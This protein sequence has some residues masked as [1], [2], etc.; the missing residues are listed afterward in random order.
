MS[1]DP[2]DTAEARIRRAK[3][4]NL[5]VVIA[6]VAL[7]IWLI[8]SVTEAIKFYLAVQGVEYDALTGLAVLVIVGSITIAFSIILAW[9]LRRRAA[10]RLAL[11]I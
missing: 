1:P 9:A 10:M 3:L 2:S 6:T 8:L 7:F 5:I 4:D 11:L